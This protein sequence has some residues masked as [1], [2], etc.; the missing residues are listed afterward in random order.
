MSF[1]KTNNYSLSTFL[2]EKFLNNT[3][4]IYNTFLL[5]KTKIPNVSY[6]KDAVLLLN[7]NVKFY[8]F[9]IPK[10]KIDKYAGNQYSCFYFFSSQNVNENFYIESELIAKESLLFEGYLYDTKTDKREYLITD[11]LVKNDIPLDFS[12]EDRRRQIVK[13]QDYF[14]SIYNDNI[15][16]NI[17]HYITDA[18]MI[19]MFKANFIYNVN[20]IETITHDFKKSSKLHVINKPDTT[21]SIEKTEKTEIYNVKDIST[22]NDMGVLY[23]K[24]LNDSRKMR[25]LFMDKTVTTLLCKY[26]TTFHKWSPIF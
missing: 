13:F 2:Q 3:L 4:S 19:D 20:C 12:Y 9:I 22:N 8:L 6:C 21:M 18:K 1:R 11:F 16:I 14:N 25:E 7:N 23:I 24:T 26:N 5:K 10:S 17:H 15:S